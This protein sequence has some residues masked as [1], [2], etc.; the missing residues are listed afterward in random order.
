M[1]PQ[2]RSPTPAARGVIIADDHP[3]VRSALRS[4]VAGLPNLTVDAEAENGLEAIS[5]AKAHQPRLMTLD[6]GMPLASGMEVFSEVRRWSPK[7]AIAVVTGFTARGHLSDWRAA[8]PEGL[9]LKTDSP[10]AMR[11]GLIDVLSGRRHQSAA[12]RA[13]LSETDAPIDLTQRERQVLHL[14]ADGASNREMAER[15]GISAKTVDRHRTNLMEKLGVRSVAQ[16]LAYALKE[17]LLDR[18]SQLKM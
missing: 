4:V 3:L 14:V 12:V 18:H 5:L 8:T 13:I 9:F 11:A 17:G 7:T 1:C 2:R 16:L 15:L 6:S 10:D